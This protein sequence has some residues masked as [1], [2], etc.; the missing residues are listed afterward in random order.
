MQIGVVSDTHSTELPPKMMKDFEKVDLI[1]H[2]G[3]FCDLSVYK[4]FAAI[5]ETKAVAGNMDEE[6]IRGEFP[7]KQVIECD[8]VKIG[9]CHG[10]SSSN[11]VLDIVK[12]IF[13]NDKIDVVIFGHSHTPFNENIGGVL[14][15]NPGSPTDTI[16][17]PYRSYGILN[18]SDGSV[19][20]KIIKVED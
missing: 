6:S 12:D 8:G 9:V 17:A 7:G 19:S 5:K 2:A 3:D 18:I 1:I 10:S 14:Y 15:F 4:V 11:K 16:F 20:G 13:K